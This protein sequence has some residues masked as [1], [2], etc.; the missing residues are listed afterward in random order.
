MIEI[1]ELNKE[2]KLAMKHFKNAVG[3]AKRNMIIGEVNFP[4]KEK[5]VVKQ[6]LKKLAK[7]TPETEGK[8]IN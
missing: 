3:M 1:K 2:L 5:K 6:R 7:V 8:E 4:A